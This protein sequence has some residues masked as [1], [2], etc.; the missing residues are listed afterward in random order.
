MVTIG[1]DPHKQTHSGVA[2]DPLG[3]RG[4]AADRRRSARRV[5][6]A[7]GVGRKLDAERVWV[8][9]D[10]RH[11]S[12]VVGAVFDRSR[13]DGRPAPAAVDGQRPPRGPRAREVRSDRRAG[14]R[15]RRAARGHRD[16]ADRA[17]GR[18]RSSRSG[19]WRCIA[20]GWSTRRTR[21]INEL[22]WQ[23]HDLWPDWE[24]PKRVLIQPGWQT[25][26][27][28][29]PAARRADGPGPDR[30]RHDPPDPRTDPHDHRALRGARRPRRAGRARSCSPRRA[31]GADRGQ[32][33]RR[34]RRHRPLQ[35]ATR[36]SR[37]SPAARRSPSHLDAPIATASIQAATAS[38]TT[39]S[40]CSR[41]PRSAT[42]PRPRST[43]PSNAPT[44]RPTREAIRC[45]KRHLVRRVYN[46]LHDPNSVPTTV[47][48]T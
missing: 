46:L 48:L 32:A 17:A 21:M 15:P 28:A 39:R 18:R 29:T 5:R 31:R 2:V 13:R 10:V 23:L 37:G 4:R 34:D 43:S 1:I 35:P 30:A 47:C 33:D 27:T 12:G 36:N 24:I 38:S 7:V 42:T 20:N 3:V 16:A 22:R 11:V 19:C 14:D 25:K 40:T 8:I 6:S 9:E 44:A 41:S 45:L 26:V